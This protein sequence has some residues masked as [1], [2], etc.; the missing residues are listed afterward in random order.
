MTKKTSKA[1]DVV[2]Q[3]LCADPSLEHIKISID[4]DNFVETE[5]KYKDGTLEKE[6]SDH[7]QWLETQS[8]PPAD[9]L[10]GYDTLE[11]P[12]CD[13]KC[14]P[15]A[16]RKD[17]TVIYERHKCKGPYDLESSMQ[18]FEINVDGEIVE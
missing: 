6:K 12:N 9:D 17:G 15:D 5:F 11:C 7:Q 8:A 1:F 16:I 14:K 2:K 10:G 18:C 13:K 3:Y 4:S